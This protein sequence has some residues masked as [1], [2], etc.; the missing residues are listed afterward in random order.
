MSSLS[1]LKEE[2]KYRAEISTSMEGYLAGVE[3]LNTL[4]KT[5]KDTTKFIAKLEEEKNN[6]IGQQKIKLEEQIKYLKEQTL[7]Y[8]RQIKMIKLAV[9]EANKYQMALLSAGKA[10][11]NGLA[12]L[13]GEVQR[14]W[15]KLKSFGLFEMDKAVKNSALQMGLLGKEGS[16]YAESIRKTAASTNEIG[17]NI[18]ALAKMQ[19]QYTE[20]LGRSVMLGDKG[21]KSMAAMSVAT[22]LG[23]EGAGELAVN[24]EEVGISAERTGDFINQTMNDSHK[25]G[26]NASKVVKNIAGNIK[27]LNKYHFKDGIRGL[28]KMAELTTKL[29]IKMDFAAGMS[30]KLWD[31][32]GA[33]DMSAQLQVM[34]GAWAKMADP[35]HLMYM[36][37]EDMAGLTKEIATASQESMHFAKDG[38]IEM[39]SMAMSKLKIIAQQTGLEY[40]DLV[41]SGKE[42]FKMNKVKSQIGLGVDEETKEFIASTAQM[43]D[44]K[45]TIEINGNP[46]LV[47]QLTG[48][49]QTWLKGQVAEKK[50]MVERAEAAQNFQDQIENLMNQIKTYMLPII[51]GINQTLGPIV[52]DFMKDPNWKGDLIKLGKDIGEFIKGLK[53]IF[54]TIGSLILALGPKGTLAVL[55]GGKFLLDAGKWILNGVALG[56][57]FLGV[58]KGATAATGLAGKLGGG[59]RG[60]LGAAGIYGAAG[61]GVGM[62]TDY[63]SQK[64]KDA[65]NENLGKGIGVLG[66]SAEY[67]LYGAAIGSLIP[68]LGTAIGA[69]IGAV[70]GAGKGLYDQNVASPSND[71]FFGSP[72]HDGMSFGGMIGGGMLGGPLGALLGSY[73]GGKF[74]GDFSKGRGVI[75]GGKIHPIDNKDDLLAMKK[76]GVIDKANQS[77]NIPA[78]VHHTFDDIVING[79]L[80]LNTPGNPG[81]GVNLLKDA[82]FIRQITNLIHVET[83]RMMN[84]KQTG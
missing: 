34:G 24:M 37:R 48:S 23:A 52:K 30:D 72:M 84:Q 66:K 33:V 9:K 17:V 3:K 28:A 15:G 5:V 13:P 80:T 19:G 26:L 81:K 82:H 21:L 58:T 32:E 56:Q 38:S 70:A 29:G 83:K 35:F 64:A 55:F 45:A 7:E 47:S 6:A 25:M 12:K 11:I 46:K 42:M 8:N 63:G 67:A 68:V 2:A 49:D 44:G 16:S 20:D 79:S 50:S 54:T 65:G 36:A 69:G 1:D 53:P 57:G 73:M 14:Q 71:G 31:I 60:G 74:G 41:K 62:L 75:Q 59:V 76:G 51:N 4:Q 77:A 39:S 78:N 22:G 27:M 10:G 61:Y 43:K 40:D 18:E